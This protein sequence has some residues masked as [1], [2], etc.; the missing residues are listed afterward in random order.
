MNMVIS[1][2]AY[3]ALPGRQLFAGIPTL[4][5]RFKDTNY[6]TLVFVCASR[7]HQHR[8]RWDAFHIET[9]PITFTP[10]S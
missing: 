8:P 3:E 1:A 9:H 10:V 4:D 7:D 6:P 5:Q 2:E